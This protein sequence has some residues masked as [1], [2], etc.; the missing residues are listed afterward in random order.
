MVAA[1]TFHIVLTSS[2]SLVE[3]DMSLSHQPGFPGCLPNWR[4]YSGFSGLAARLTRGV[5]GYQQLRQPEQW[6]KGLI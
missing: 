3:P 4:E 6:S 2:W 1:R 5:D